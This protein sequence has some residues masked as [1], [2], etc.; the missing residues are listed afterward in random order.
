MQVHAL[1]SKEDDLTQLISSQQ[2]ASLTHAAQLSSSQQKNLTLH[3]QH[4]YRSYLLENCFPVRIPIP[5]A[6]S[7]SHLHRVVCRALVTLCTL[8]CTVC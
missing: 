4:M 8:Y 2:Q 5:A 7:A 6:W 1:Q 3:Q